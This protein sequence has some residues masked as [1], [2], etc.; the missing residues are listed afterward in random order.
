ME[1]KEYF[2][3]VMQDY[4]QHRKG[5]NLRKYCSDEGIDYKWLV[6][7][8][9]NYGACKPSSKDVNQDQSGFIPIQVIEERFDNPKSE[10]A[11]AG[12]SIKQVV[13]S[14]PGG[15]DIEIRSNN[16]AAFLE[17]LRKMIS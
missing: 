2:E 10:S 14:A 15:D 16:L 13:L 12:W 17:L 8:K 6:E 5:R 9:K 11:G 7:Y 3:K 1:T 4:N